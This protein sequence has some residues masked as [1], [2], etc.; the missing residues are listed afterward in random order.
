MV[1]AVIRQRFV[2]V[3]QNLAQDSDADV[4]YFA[5]DPLTVVN[6]SWW[7]VHKYVH[8]HVLLYAHSDGSIL[9]ESEQ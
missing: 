2:P 7:Y 1:T 6:V 3:L 4:Q 5:S 9:F 8:V